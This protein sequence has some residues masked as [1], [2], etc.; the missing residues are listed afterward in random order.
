M[1]TQ[2]G[3]IGERTCFHDATTAGQR[4]EIAQ[5]CALLPALP[6]RLDQGADVELT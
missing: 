6:A 5:M 3:G 1:G 4:F 2:S